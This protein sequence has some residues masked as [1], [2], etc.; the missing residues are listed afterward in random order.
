[1]IL[2]LKRTIRVKCS[3]LKETRQFKSDTVTNL[4]V[5]WFLKVYIE[6]NG[7]DDNVSI[8]LHATPQSS[9]W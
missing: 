7:D 4:G 3:N 1:M 8:Y 5:D 2:F 6:K 9:T